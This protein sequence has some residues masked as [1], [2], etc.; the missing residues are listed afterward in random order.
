MQILITAIG[1]LKRGPDLELFERYAKRVSQLGD[2]IALGPLTVAELNESKTANAIG[3]RTDEADW[4]TKAA[5]QAD[6][7]VLVDER[8]KQF[9]SRAFATFLRTQ[10]D[11]GTRTMAFL[12]GGPDGHG[13]HACNAAQTTL[14]LGPMTLPHGLA[15]IVLAEQLYRAITILTGHPYHRE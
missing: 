8:G 14:S 5:Q 4:L 11:G 12:I 3:R 6:H 10:R 9:S 1:R 2:R 7:K 13:E 15:R